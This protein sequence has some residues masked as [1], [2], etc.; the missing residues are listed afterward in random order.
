M[1]KGGRFAECPPYAPPHGRLAAIPNEDTI[2]SEM[3]GPQA[4]YFHCKMRGFATQQIED[5]PH[6]Q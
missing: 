1:K 4:K 2:F 3:P 5:H 6:P